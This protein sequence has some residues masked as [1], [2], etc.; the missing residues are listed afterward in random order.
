M[1]SYQES[2]TVNYPYQSVLQA[3]KQ[4]PAEQFQRIREHPL[5]FRCANDPMSKELQVEVQS[6]DTS[7]TLLHLQIQGEQSDTL[8]DTFLDVLGSELKKQPVIEATP[9]EKPHPLVT[10]LKIFCIMV[11]IAGIVA[12]IHLSYI[13][14]SYGTYIEYYFDIATFLLTCFLFL[15]AAMLFYAL[16]ELFHLLDKRL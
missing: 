9:K 14:V 2:Y 3:L 12:A 1:T 13:P 6:K 7:T 10:Q 8:R 5:T 15:M 11:V 4:L 16:A